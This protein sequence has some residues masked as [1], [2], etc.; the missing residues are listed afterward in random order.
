MLELNGLRMSDFKNHQEA[1]KTADDFVKQ[2]QKDFEHSHPDIKHDNPLLVKVF[3]VAG[4]GKKRTFKQDEKKEFTLDGD[5]KSQKQLQDAS[6]F[7]EGMGMGV[8]S[9]SSGG[10]VKIEHVAFAKMNTQ[11]DSLRTGLA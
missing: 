4:Q 5:V 7:I 10:D 1:L 6:M 3:Y 2:N 8:G 9:S 11:K